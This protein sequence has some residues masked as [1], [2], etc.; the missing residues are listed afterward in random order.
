MNHSWKDIART[1]G[2]VSDWVPTA[3][4]TV[5]FQGSGGWASEHG[6]EGGDREAVPGDD[7]GFVHP[8]KAVFGGIHST[9]NPGWPGLKEKD[10]GESRQHA[11]ERKMHK[12]PHFAMIDDSTPRQK[13]RAQEGM[14]KS[15]GGLHHAREERG[16]VRRV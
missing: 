15:R 10:Y 6:D 16:R 3:R 13:V 2:W 11:F 14:R 7:D 1:N 4:V 12:L 9:T 5:Q 8:S